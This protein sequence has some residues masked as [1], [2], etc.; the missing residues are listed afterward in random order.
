MVYIGY[1]NLLFQLGFVLLV[2]GVL[3]L[4]LVHWFRRPL[5]TSGNFKFLTARGIAEWLKLD[6]FMSLAATAVAVGGVTII[7]GIIAWRLGN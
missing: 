5:A 7:L 6:G 1:P 2:V 3:G 4:L